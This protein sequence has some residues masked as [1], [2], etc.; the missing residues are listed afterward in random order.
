M[1]VKSIRGTNVV[2]IM[3]RQTI[4]N[5]RALAQVEGFWDALCR[6][7]ALPSRS[8]IDP[9]GM[10]EALEYAFVLE[11]IAP[12]IGRFRIAGMHLNELMGMEVRGMPLSAMFLPE[13]RKELG[14][15]VETTCAEPQ[16]TT[17][18]LKGA[19]SIGRP[20]IEAQMLL[21]PLCDDFGE[22]TRILGCLQSKGRIGRQP[23][24]F[25]IAH[26]QSQ[27]ICTKHFFYPVQQDQHNLADPSGHYTPKLTNKGPDDKRPALRWL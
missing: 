11:R 13:S 17:L 4:L 18:T 8:Q 3:S 10:E 9:R 7:D 5:Y 21:L 26:T 14:K 25:S 6:D 27:P 19:G 12:G 1:K 16:V 2:S 23:R 22:V 15:M 24:R 20:R